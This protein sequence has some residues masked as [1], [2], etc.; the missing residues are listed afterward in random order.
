M[1]GVLQHGGEAAAPVGGIQ[2]GEA[3]FGAVKRAHW[4]AVRR[5]RSGNKF[6]QG[7]GNR[8]SVPEHQTA[9]EG[10]GEEEEG[11]GAE[12]TEG[13]DG[14]VHAKDRRVAAVVGMGGTGEGI[15]TMLLLT[16]PL[17]LARK[18][19]QALPLLP[20]PPPSRLLLMLTWLAT[21][22]F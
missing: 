13:G 14:G 5:C 16:L 4:M 11:G 1:A 9:V 17:M 3:T 19:L 8:A 21:E 12:R 2:R 7:S 20:N 15:T 10:G 22:A 6:E 18:L